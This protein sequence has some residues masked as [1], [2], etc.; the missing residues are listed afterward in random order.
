ML[1]SPAELRCI[2]IARTFRVRKVEEKIADF[3]RRNKLSM[4]FMEPIIL[5]ELEDGPLADSKKPVR[6]LLFLLLIV[7]LYPFIWITEFISWIR[8]RKIVGEERKNLLEELRI[9]KV[10]SEVSEHKSFLQLWSDHGL[11]D[12]GIGYTEH[13]RYNK[14][15][16]LQCLSEWIKIL[17]ASEIDLEEFVE[18][19]GK[20]NREKIREYIRENPGI[21]VTL[22]DPIDLAIFE[23]DRL[24]GNYCLERGIREFSRN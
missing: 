1:P 17:Y 24:F 9:I 19:V 7:V 11:R 20:H 16:K 22:A 2:E 10:K 18:Q 5:A 21:H 4:T 6:S 3:E 13:G 12:F 14:K 23:I 15:E 8:N